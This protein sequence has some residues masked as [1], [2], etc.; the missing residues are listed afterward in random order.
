MSSD[1]T[2]QSARKSLSKGLLYTERLRIF[3]ILIV[4]FLLFQSFNY[5]GSFQS[6]SPTLRGTFDLPLPV[7]S[8][9]RMN[10]RQLCKL[11]RGI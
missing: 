8:I 1:N 4:V 3:G 9:F 10:A 11:D 7:S 2:S 5:C 6:K